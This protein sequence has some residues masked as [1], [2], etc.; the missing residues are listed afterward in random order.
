VGLIFIPFAAWFYGNT[1]DLDTYPAL[2]G[3]GFLGS[4]G[5]PVITIPLLLDLAE[6]PGDIFNL[7]LASGVIAARFGD[8]MKTMH[9]LAF[10]MV[11][12]CVLNGTFRFHWRRILFSAGPSILLILLSAALIRGW[13]DSNFKDRYSKAALITEREM[14]F[15]RSR[16][17]SNI[18]PILLNESEPNPNPIAE[19]QSRIDRIKQRG[20]I[21]I[22][23]DQGKMPF[24]Y[25]NA[26]GQLIGFDIE[27]AY[28]LADDLQVNIEFVPIDRENLFRQLI[29]DHFDVAMSAIEGTVN[30]ATELPS[31]D[32][33]MDV[34]LA[35]VVPDHQKRNF[36]T[37]NEILKIHDLKLATV[38]NSFFA[39][40]APRVLPENVQL[41]ELE[42]A[43]EYFE[44]KHREANGLV[45]SAESGSAWTLRYPQFSVTNPLASRIRVP[46]YYLTANDTEFQKFLQNWQTLKR[47]DGTYQQL[48]DYW[49]LGLDNQS[50]DPRWCI[51]RDVLHWIE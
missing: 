48:Y 15:P 19:G 49:I 38:K 14:E 13:L 12:S 39:D 7:F 51:L 36:R 10:T 4:F 25:F 41:I 27:M 24:A 45:I 40:R 16:P 47:S 50:Q 20:L 29:D 37:R 32:S 43:S 33:Y 17:L 31:I 9:M 11:V 21:R 2:L 1:I 30:Q 35:I 34:T 28:Y 5:K 42:S 6:L 18:N 26:T 22:G 46:L 23:F 8:L 3:V 44:D